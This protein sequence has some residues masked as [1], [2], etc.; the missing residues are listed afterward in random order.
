MKASDKKRESTRSTFK[1]LFYLNRSK[2]QKDGSMPIVCRI[3]V[4]GKSESLSTG[5]KCRDYRGE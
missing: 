5:Q 2:A 4:D 3:S 1:L